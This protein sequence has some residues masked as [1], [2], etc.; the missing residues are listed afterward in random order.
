[1]TIAFNSLVTD[2][3]TTEVFWE[4]FQKSFSKSEI[5]MKFYMYKDMVKVMYEPKD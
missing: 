3:S 5:C 4:S 2:E 1:M